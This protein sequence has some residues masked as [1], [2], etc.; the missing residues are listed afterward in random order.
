MTHHTR[1]VQ[2]C[3]LT[4]IFVALSTAPALAQ[5]GPRRSTSHGLLVSMRSSTRR[6]RSRNC[7]APCC[8]SA[9]A[10]ARSTS[11]PTAARADANSRDDDAGHD[12]RSRLAHQACGD[13]DERH[14]PDRAGKIRLNDRVAMFIPE[15]RKYG[16]EAI[17][18]R[19]LLTHV[20]GLRPDVDLADMWSG[21]IK[22]SSWRSKR[23][24][25]QR[26]A[27]GSFTATSTS[28]FLAKSFVV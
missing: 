17:T 7:L 11:R 14:D 26:R 9:A 25:S 8:S 6:S 22:R 21:T 4:C 2:H 28:F 1:I 3:W 13:D 15:R 27:N 12:F 18:V 5:V 16:K 20:S 19:H 23:S 10:T 24:R